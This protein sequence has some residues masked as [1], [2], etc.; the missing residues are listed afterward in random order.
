MV[1]NGT[2]LIE[3]AHR[4]LLS[5]HK[6]IYSQSRCFNRKTMKKLRQNLN[7]G[8]TVLLFLLLL[9]HKGKHLQYCFIF[10]V[11]NFLQ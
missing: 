8:L 11:N 3:S 10:L 2:E 6:T 7:E 5:S 1:N 4:V 9:S